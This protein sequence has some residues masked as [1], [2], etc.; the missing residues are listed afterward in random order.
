MNN[1]RIY[2]RIALA[3]SVL[4]F[5]LL[6]CDAGAAIV[7]EAAN[8]YVDSNFD[9]SERTQVSAVL[10]KNSG[11]LYFYVEKG[12]W[13]LQP[14][15]EKDKISANLDVLAGEFD[16]KIYPRLT[17]FFGS[18][19]K[20][21]VDGDNKITILFHNMKEDSGG[22]FRT[23]DE[24]VKLQVPDSNEREM[25][26]LPVNQVGSLQ[27]K[28]LL[29]HEFVHLITFNQKNKISG[30]DEE[31]WLNEIRAD[32]SSTI[33]GY[34]DIYSGSNL[35]KRVN[36]FLQK[37]S[38]PLTEWQN[39]KYDYAVISMFAHYLV[40]HYGISILTDSI[41]LKSAGIESLNEVLT[42]NGADEKFDEIYTNW[43]I[44]LVVNNCS[45]GTKFCY[46]SENLSKIKIN[47]AI[48]FLPMVGSSTLSVANVAKNWSGSW[49]KF[50][51]GSGDLR[52]DF[53]SLSAL[54]F[55]VPYI[56]F[57]K[58]NQY[59]VK[60]LE[61]DKDSKG[62]LEIKNFGSE[63]SSL[64]IIPTLQTKT[65]GFNGLELTYPYTFTVSVAGGTNQEDQTLIE[66]LLEQIDSLKKQ[67]ALLQAQKGGNEENVCSELNR[68]LY[69]GINNNSDVQCLQTF[70]KLQGPDIYPEGLVTGNFGSLTRKAVMK[71]QQKYAPEVLKPA[72]LSYATGY[73]GVL[74][75]AKINQLLK[76][77]F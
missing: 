76:G 19:W 37:P 61:L 6:G 39:T 38:D 1:N 3:S 64:V 41:K 33:L 50:I 26:Y 10:L 16:S 56:I 51:G 66:K 63:Y 8:F 40:D 21:G 43:T 47:P 9:A 5:L 57:D 73:V 42:R 35:Q 45:G 75:R 11:R 18:E 13:D 53:S 77:A 27:V 2:K 55:K 68:N 17:S 44:A 65:S 71:F 20:P 23:A 67:I 22:Y 70:L 52:F 4:L 34:D 60:Y 69:M 49:Q 30:S 59:A 46:L 28:I 72:G 58:N 24:Y 54:K 32:Y 12:W 31:V 74:T 36:D 48:N 29:A 14:Q 15:V 62:T 25:L 7:G